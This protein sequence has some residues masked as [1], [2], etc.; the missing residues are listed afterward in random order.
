MKKSLFTFT[1]LAVGATLACGQEVAKAGDVVNPPVAEVSKGS[2]AEAQQMMAA[3]REE[4]DTF[5]EAYSAAK[6]TEERQELLKNRP[7]A[8]DRTGKVLKIVRDNLESETADGLL[9]WVL[10]NGTAAEK[11]ESLALMLAHFN[12][13][14][15]LLGYVQ[16]LGY[17][18]P[19]EDLDKVIK[20]AGDEKVRLTA[21]LGL[22]SFVANE[23]ERNKELTDEERKAKTEEAKKL[24]NE[25]VA[26]GG[27]KDNHPKL[28]ATA[29]GK[30]FKINNLTIG[31]VAPEIVGV[32]HAGE[33]FKLS[34]YR[35]K[36]TLVDFWGIW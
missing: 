17:Y 32:D 36:V 23:G 21:Q 5:R 3:L 4:A 2:L 30:L 9:E 28:A 16:R 14:P 34:D 33:E 26:V 20:M 12:E 11:S 13:S 7:M 31:C 22:A 27:V 1:A 29:E 25:L 19:R 10:A 24:L 8:G 35:G 18:G 6:S 15:K